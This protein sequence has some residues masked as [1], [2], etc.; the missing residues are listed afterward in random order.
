MSVNNLTLERN[1]TYP[2]TFTHIESMTGGKLYVT[3]KSEQYDDIENDSSAVFPPKII[4]SFTHNS[5]V[6]IN[7]VST[8]ITGNYATWEFTDQDL[9]LEPGTY[10]YDIVFEDS[11]GRAQP[12]LSQGKLKIVGHPT[13]RTALA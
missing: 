13:N 7:G 2:C 8:T 5:P 6:L 1:T 12:V 9:Y 11:T 3:V 10:Y 4:T